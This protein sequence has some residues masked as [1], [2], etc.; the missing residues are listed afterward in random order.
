MIFLGKK[1]FWWKWDKFTIEKQQPSLLKQILG[2]NGSTQNNSV[3]VEF[4]RL[5]LLVNTHARVWNYIK[6]LKNKTDSSAK[7][8]Y[9]IDLGMDNNNYI[10]KDCEF[11]HKIAN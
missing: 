5:P 10:F 7:E 6:Y 4:S 3:R 1:P 11:G 9:Q 2:L 8:T